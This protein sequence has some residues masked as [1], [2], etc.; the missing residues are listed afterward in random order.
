MRCR[1]ARDSHGY[2][3]VTVNFRGVIHVVC[4]LGF[5]L[6][7]LLEDDAKCIERVHNREPAAQPAPRATASRALPPALVPLKDHSF[8]SRLSGNSDDSDSQRAPG[9]DVVACAARGRDAG[10]DVQA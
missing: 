4:Q 7:C 8:E 6:A 3:I 5:Q 10:A 1:M 9:G 2:E